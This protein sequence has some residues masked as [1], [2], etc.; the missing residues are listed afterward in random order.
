MRVPTFELERWQS[1]WENQVEVN[2]S[3]SGVLPL[4]VAELLPDEQAI[5]ALLNT[6]LGYPQTNGSEETRARI[7]ALYPGATASNVLVTTGCAE[8]NFL[9]TWSLLEPGDEAA[10][11][12]PNY[13]QVGLLAASFGANVHELRLREDLQWSFDADDLRRLVN[14]RTKL[15]AIC[16]PNNPTGAVMSEAAMKA[17]CDCAAEVGAWILADEVYRGAEL[18]GELTPTFW[19]CYERVLC[20]AGLSKAYSLPGLRTGWVV[21]PADFVDKLWSYHDYTSIGI[22]KLS[23]RLAAAALATDTRLRI[24]ERVQR[25][26]NENYPVVQGW[27]K[28]HADQFRHIPPVAGGVAWFGYDFDW[29]ADQLSDELRRRKGVLIVPGTQFGSGFENFVRIGFA[30]D[31]EHL[32]QGLHRFDELLA[33]TPALQA[34]RAS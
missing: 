31:A 2:I 9:I 18:A 8:A 14:K 17:V 22:S 25:V 15:I 20:T 29:P 4:T 26:L 19:G 1:V 13:M 32:R 34:A 21:G 7:A 28:Q 11:M 23:D 24:R 6:P 12:V 3:E 33:E 5:A 30:G 27:V 10:F 16:N